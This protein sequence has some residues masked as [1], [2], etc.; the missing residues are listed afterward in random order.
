MALVLAKG[1]FEGNELFKVFWA[2]RHKYEAEN[3]TSINYLVP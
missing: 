1:H 2:H 3:T